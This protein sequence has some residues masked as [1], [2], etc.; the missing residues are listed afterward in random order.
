LGERRGANFLRAICEAYADLLPRGFI[1]RVRPVV[2]DADVLL[3]EIVAEVKRPG[4]VVL[5]AACQ[6][7]FLRIYVAESVLGEVENNLA[8][9]CAE[10]AR[11]YTAARAVWASWRPH[12]RVI[13]LHDDV[14]AEVLPVFQRH[15]ADVP[16]ARLS[17]TL[18]RGLTWSND[19]HL[20]ST[21]FAQRYPLHAALAVRAVSRG[22]MSAH[23]AMRISTESVAAVLRLV[24]RAWLA[25]GP[26]QRVAVLGGIAAI[27]LA[28]VAVRSRITPTLSD[29][30]P[31]ILAALGEGFERIT[32]WRNLELRKVPALPAI[33]ANLRLEHAIAR[34]LA[35]AAAPLTAPEIARRIA[36][37]GI[38]VS[39]QQVRDALGAS[40]MFVRSGR[41]FWQL[42]L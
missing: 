22:E 15:P 32:E 20:R 3:K 4:E 35:Y 16:T 30:V 28:A 39:D 40:P 12:L 2:I 26:M 38:K 23:T 34:L 8:R 13:S 25:A 14:P 6:L 36:L 9:V 33:D 24:C 1:L 19:R 7:G 27:V 18:G 5:Y 17:L 10:T 21:G 29:S 37:H 41:W 11:D 42:G 31:R